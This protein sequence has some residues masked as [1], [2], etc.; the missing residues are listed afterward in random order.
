MMA[1]GRE[2]GS[3]LTHFGAARRCS[4]WP[5]RYIGAMI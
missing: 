2:T 5:Q 4:D 1:F 3:P